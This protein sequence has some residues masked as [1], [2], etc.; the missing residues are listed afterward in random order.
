MCTMTLEIVQIIEDDPD[1]A[2]LLDHTLRRAQYRTNVA[3]DGESGLADVRRLSPA[4]ILL[5]VMLPG[6]DGYDLCRQ[7]REDPLTRSIAIVLLTA[8]G[9]EEHRVRGFDL[10]ADDYIVKPFSPR[11]VVARVGAVLRRNR[12]GG[13]AV[14]SLL[15][16]GL[17][18]E[19]QEVMAFLYGRPLRLTPAEWTVLR[20][21][22]RAV[23]RVVTRE[24]LATALWGQDEAQGET[25][26]RH[27]VDRIRQ[28]V[29]DIPTVSVETVRG[30]GYRFCTVDSRRNSR[31]LR[32][33]S[34]GSPKQS[35]LGPV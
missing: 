25:A 6:L 32:R 29:V 17:V 28:R 7:F 23:N 30:V 10:G 8:L 20:T 15:D 16:G 12:G 22:A 34:L 9:A 1:Q 13:E 2:A 19:R 4:L 24:E 11:E 18:F 26:L 27:L 33:E 14:E 3:H 35:P 5:D 21:L 31:A